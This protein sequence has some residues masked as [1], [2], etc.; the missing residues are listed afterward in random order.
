MRNISLLP[1]EYKSYK[2]SEKRISRFA[3]ITAVLVLA[4]VLIYA[5]L[6]VSLVALRSE[7]DTIRR[8]REHIQLKTAELQPYEAM[9]EKVSNAQALYEQIMSDNPDWSSLLVQIFDSIPQSL[10]FDSFTIDYPNN[11]GALNIKGWADSHST[12]ADWMALLKDNE[13]LSNVLYKSSSISGADNSLEG[14][15]TVQFEISAQLVGVR[16]LTESAA[17]AEEGGR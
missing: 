7:A 3:V 17:S 13:N 14:S 8:Q 15:T 12:V 5:T 9:K 2:K 4:F 6:S 16:A 1:A 10:W 11:A